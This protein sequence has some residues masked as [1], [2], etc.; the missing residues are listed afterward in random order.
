M[1]ELVEIEG[2]TELRRAMRQAADAT[3]A[4]LSRALREASKVLQRRM[5]ALAPSRDG[6][7]RA[8]IRPFSTATSSGARSRLPYA[9][10][11]EFAKAYRRTRAGK[12]HRVVMH[13]VGEPPRFGYKALDQVQDELIAA[14]HEAIITLLAAKGWL[15]ITEA[16]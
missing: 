4:E 8:S 5:V 6:K 11:Q 13:N 16:A 12:T 7:L 1:P 2:L 3:P 10:V 9:A 15:E 14:V